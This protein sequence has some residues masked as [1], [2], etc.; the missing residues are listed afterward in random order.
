MS[1]EVTRKELSALTG[2]KVSE[3]T[4]CNREKDWGLDK[5]R[6]PYSAHPVLYDEQKAIRQLKKA[7]RITFRKVA[8]VAGGV[9]DCAS[10]TATGATQTGNPRPTLVQS[11]G[12][13]FD[14]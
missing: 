6:K 7:N 1:R 13:R 14:D 10:G 12:R 11:S 3:R 2:N 4:I 9:T 5:C 8:N